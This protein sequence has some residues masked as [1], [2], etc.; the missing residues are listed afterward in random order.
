[1]AYETGNRYYIDG[2][3]P[4]DHCAVFGVFDQNSQSVHP[5]TEVYYGLYSLQHRGL[6]SSGIIATDGDQFRMHRR[7]GLVSHVYGKG[8]IE[9]LEG[10]AAIGHN[11]YGTDGGEGHMQ[12]VYFEDDLV[13][14]G[15]N[16]HL[17]YVRKLYEFVERFHSNP[18][19]L[20]DSELAQQALNH[21]MKR[22][23]SLEDAI[24]ETMPL[25]NGAYSMV[26]LTKDKMAGVRDPY[27]IRPFTLG[28]INGGYALS[29]ETCGLDNISAIHLGNVNPGEMVVIDHDGIK[30]EQLMA[31]NLKS[32]AYEWFYLSRPDSIL[33]GQNVYSV[34]ERLGMRLAEECPVDADVVIGVPDSGIPGAM[35]FAKASGI[36]YE[37]GFIKNPYVGRTF[38]TPDKRLRSRKVQLKMNP[39]I[40]HVEGKRVVM[41]DDSRVRNT[42]AKEIVP[43][44]YEA[45]AK[46]VHERFT[47]PELRYPS[48]TGVATATYEE[49][50]ANK[51]TRE[52]LM[53]I[54]GSKSIGHVSIEGFVQSTGLR[55]DQLDLS[56]FNGEYVIK[57]E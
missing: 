33:E 41:V 53:E 39:V 5:A 48:I 26:M 42:S 17:Q 21:H 52:E 34:R 1:M 57:P 16:G 10:F 2:N 8:D 19:A 51:Y 29:S 6:D 54:N 49:H 44:L 50:A 15:H 46:E 47:S 7:G 14:L 38:I 31:P 27:G 18:S 45:G 55:A 4:K 25:L 56:A 37:T 28:K 30:R 3:K 23:A 36:P 22:G 20:N 43:M 35:G 24:A 32:D 13:A 12:P 9:K 11:R 40:P